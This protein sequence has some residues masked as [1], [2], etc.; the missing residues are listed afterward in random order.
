MP[1]DL[2]CPERSEDALL[3][4]RISQK[5]SV[6]PFVLFRN[7]PGSYVFIRALPG[8]ELK[9]ENPALFSL[10][11]CRMGVSFSGIS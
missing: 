8:V 5:V 4:K 2:Q 1:S 3:K 11:A 10:F 7:F 6:E 9:S